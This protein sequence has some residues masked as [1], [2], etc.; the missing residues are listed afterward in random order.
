[1]PRYEALY[2]RGAY[3]PRKER[4]RL[5]RMVRKG[6]SPLGF[7]RVEDRGSDFEQDPPVAIGPPISVARQESLF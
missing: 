7:R 5:A 2:R 4:E 1:V 6:R 3:A